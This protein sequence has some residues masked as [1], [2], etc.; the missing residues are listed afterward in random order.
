VSYNKK[1]SYADIVRTPQVPKK[2][3]FLRLNYPENYQL[4]F[5]SSGVKHLKRD[6]PASVAPAFVAPARPMDSNPRANLNSKPKRVLRWVPKKVQSSP[7]I[8]NNLK[9][10]VSQEHSNAKVL[11][12]NPSVKPRIPQSP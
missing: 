9:R 1:K 3:V 8:A 6:K 10:A 2:K 11:N 5:V 4:N 7:V 12:S